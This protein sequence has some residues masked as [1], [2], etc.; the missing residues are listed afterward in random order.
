M[1]EYSQIQKYIDV[2]P[3]KD[4]IHLRDGDYEFWGY[5]PPDAVIIATGS[6]S[7]AVMLI[8]QIN[9]FNFKLKEGDV[10]RTITTPNELQSYFN[11]NISNVNGALKE[12]T[13]L[14]YLHGVALFAEPSKGE[15]SSNADPYDEALNK[16]LW[17]LYEKYEGEN[18]LIF[19]ADTV[20]KPN[21][22]SEPLGKPGNEPDFPK[23]ENFNNNDVDYKEAIEKYLQ[24]FKDRYYT[25]SKKIVHTNAFVV[26]DALTGLEMNYGALN[27]VILN[28][29]IVQNKLDEAALKPYIGG[30]GITQQLVEWENIGEVK[31]YFDALTM[32]I[33]KGESEKNIRMALFCQ[34]SGMPLAIIKYLG[35]ANRDLQEIRE[36]E[37]A[38]MKAAVEY[39][40]MAEDELFGM[41]AAVEYNRIVE[42]EK[43]G[44]LQR[45]IEQKDQEFF[46]G[47]TVIFDKKSYMNTFDDNQLREDELKGME[48]A[49]DYNRMIEVKK[50]RA[51]KRLRE[52]EVEEYK[53]FESYSSNGDTIFGKN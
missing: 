46:S 19:G 22:A 30:G 17:L 48:F 38:G 7:K 26:I 5:K 2:C 36:D 43:P 6:I 13:F 34:I 21:M 52:L 28:I 23:E 25:N 41:E 32:A 40:R 8:A 37:A 27:Y 49:A 31:S 9:G 14:G 44:F 1:F 10:Y 35:K 51:I 45:F 24:I 11:K 47:E 18:V 12:K 42:D 4:K 53:K 15:T 39:N 3:I 16:A 20:D 29:N 33:I 50:D